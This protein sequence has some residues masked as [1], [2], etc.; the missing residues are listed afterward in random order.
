MQLKFYIASTTVIKITTVRE[1]DECLKLHTLHNRLKIT[2]T[3]IY[4]TDSLLI[5]L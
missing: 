5:L 2:N 3:N 4:N 1:R